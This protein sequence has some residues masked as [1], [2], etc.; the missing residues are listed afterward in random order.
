[1]VCTVVSTP[2]SERV[3]IDGGKKT[4][5]N[6]SNMPYGYIV[7]H[8]A[9]KIY[10]MSVEHGHVDV[11]ECEH[12]FQVGERLSVIPQHQGMTTNLHDQVYAVRNGTVEAT[13]KV[14]GRGRVA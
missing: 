13:W 11:S 6:D 5:T 1:M 14:A 12:R 2:T 7:E 3:I 9:A 8:P 4:F 10:G